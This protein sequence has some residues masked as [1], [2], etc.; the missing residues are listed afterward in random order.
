MTILHWAYQVESTVKKD[1]FRAERALQL[2]FWPCDSTMPVNDKYYQL[3]STDSYS[4]ASYVWISS[5]SSQHNHE[6]YLKSH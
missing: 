1:E 6:G 2:F 5:H 4:Q 3:I